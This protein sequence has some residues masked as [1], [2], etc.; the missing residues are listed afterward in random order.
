MMETIYCRLYVFL[1]GKIK[2]LY[3]KKRNDY[4]KISAILGMNTYTSFADIDR[5]NQMVKYSQNS[6]KKIKLIPNKTLLPKSES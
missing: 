2:M 3:R 6:K 4:V 5:M 1:K